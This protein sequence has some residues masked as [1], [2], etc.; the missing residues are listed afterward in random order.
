[1]FGISLVTLLVLSLSVVAHVVPRGKPAFLS[2]N[3]RKVPRGQ[4]WH[5]KRGIG[6]GKDTPTAEVPL[7]DFFNGTD[8]QYV[9]IFVNHGSQ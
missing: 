8:L 4:P 6:S 9:D 7:Q 1:M 2:L 5:N 3:C